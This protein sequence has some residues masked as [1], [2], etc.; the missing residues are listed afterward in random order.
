[1][2]YKIVFDNAGFEQALA[3][4]GLQRTSLRHYPAL[5]RV[6]N[7]ERKGVTTSLVESI[8]NQLG[9]HPLQLLKITRSNGIE[10]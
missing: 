2:A 3:A 10:S 6:L 7:G 1:M 8:A 5:Y 9:C 4:S